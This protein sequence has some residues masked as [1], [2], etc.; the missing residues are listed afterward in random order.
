MKY[1]LKRIGMAVVTLFIVSIIVFAMFQLIPGDVVTAKLGKDATPERV[2]AMKAQYGLDK[3]LAEQYFS[4][5]G[6]IL[7]GQLGISY[8]K[9]IP[10]GQLMGNNLVV[11]ISLALMSLVL[12]ICIAMPIGFATGYLSSRK[13]KRAKIFDGIFDGIN[14]TFMAVP[15]FFIGILISV[16]FGLI[17]KWFVVGRYVS[18]EEDFIGFLIYLVPAA[19]S[20]A[21][22]KIAMLVRFVKG[23]VKEEME[24]DYVRTAKSKGMKD[25]AILFRHV[26]KNVIVTSVTVLSVIM[27]EIFA[28]SVVVEQV[29]NLPGLGRLL[30]SS[31]GTRDYPVVMDIVI[32][33]AAMIIIVNLLVDIIYRLIDPRIGASYE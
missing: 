27:A 21:I 4:W 26:F 3:P 12:I 9:D 14:Q 16:V 6:G 19:I 30:V 29:F 22:P 1:I 17:L 28:G 23:S 13:T 33:I 32:Y 11:T 18:Y 31:I 25:L 20:V 2:L 7:T 24:K 15:S 8:S 10:I 5:V